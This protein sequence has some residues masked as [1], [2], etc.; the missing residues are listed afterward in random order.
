MRTEVD[1]SFMGEHLALQ[2]ATSNDL[3]QMVKSVD[4]KFEDLTAVLKMA[5]VGHTSNSC[6][7]AVSVPDSKGLFAS[8]N[9]ESV[10]GPVRHGRHIL[11]HQRTN[12]APYAVV[13]PSNGTPNSETGPVPSTKP[14]KGIPPVEYAHIRIPD[15]GRAPGA[16]RR[17]IKQWEQI[18]PATGFALKDW[19]KAW[20]TGL[21]KDFTAQKRGLREDIAKEFYRSEF[22]NMLIN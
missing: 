15:L 5:S 12:S 2:L 3:H 21:M 7:C 19:P 17:A 11:G 14:K 9:L 4:R 18:D 16:W 10:C 20:F 6:Q 8:P 13:Q 22:L 1:Q